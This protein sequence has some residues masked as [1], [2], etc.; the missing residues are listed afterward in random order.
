MEARESEWRKERKERIFNFLFLFLLV[1]RLVVIPRANKGRGLRYCMKDRF[2]I[3]FSVVGYSLWDQFNDT[4]FCFTRYYV[5]L[6]WNEM[7][8]P[9][10]VHKVPQHWARLSFITRSRWLLLPTVQISIGLSTYINKK[11]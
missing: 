4:V 5:Y 2:S 6:Y 9:V 11:Y 10:F 8:S 7:I 3:S 1:H